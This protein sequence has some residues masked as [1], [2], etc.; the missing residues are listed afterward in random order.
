MRTPRPFHFFF[1]V[2]PY[3][4]SFGFVSVALPYVARERGIGVEAI[5]AVV[6]AAFAPHAWKF[7]WAPIVDTTL[8]RKAWYLIA[9]ALVALGTFA[10][11]AMP[12]TASSLGALTSVVVASQVGLTLLYMACEGTLGRALPKERKSTA[13]AW[14]QAGTFLGLGVGGGLA[15]ELVSRLP[16]TMAGGIIALTMLACA[17]PLLS[18]DEP[19]AG[20]PRSVPQALRDLMR[21]L[22]ALIRS[23]SGVMAIVLCLSSV[24][25]G[26]ASNL[27]GA[28]ADDWHASRGLV[29]LTNGWLG[30]IVSALGA[31]AAGWFIKR[32]DRRMAY[33]LAGAL[34]AATG[35]AMALAP[36][37]SLSYAVFTLTYGAFTGMAYAAFSA[38]AFE[39]IGSESVATKYNILASLLNLSIVFKTRLDGRAHG[40]WGGGGVLLTDSAITFAGIVLLAA[41]A[42]LTRPARR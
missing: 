10:S 41:A 11:M 38:F 8:T 20:E 13:A 22:G 3:G 26:A 27:F 32:V 14:L 16:G 15:I 2:L 28:L 6:S 4:V 1:L 23:R 31:V 37:S 30:G 29:E 21:D 35:V 39:T 5:G 18:F 36:H 19:A 24:G 40:T 33:G 17:L 7:L 25:A 34:T 42:A 9:L 12:I